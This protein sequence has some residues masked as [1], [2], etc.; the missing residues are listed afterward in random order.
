MSNLF[1]S[2]SAAGVSFR[3]GR[4]TRRRP[5]RGRRRRTTPNSRFVYHGDAAAA[6]ASTVAY[7]EHVDSEL[8][9][10]TQR[11]VRRQST[12][13]PTL[14]PSERKRLVFDRGAFV[15]YDLRG[16]PADY[17]QPNVY[18]Q[19]RIKFQTDAPSGLLWYIG[20]EDRNTHL[21]LKVIFYRADTFC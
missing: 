8:Q 9:R 7:L 14:P 20:T 15:K 16:L 4:S 5:G 3:P 19:I 18:E 10:S 1:Y 11:K 12:V 17:R 6:G 13:L 21:S 2:V